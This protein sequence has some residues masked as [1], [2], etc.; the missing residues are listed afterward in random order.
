MDSTLMTRAGPNTCVEHDDDQFSSAITPSYS[1]TYPRPFFNLLQGDAR[2][3]IPSMPQVHC[4][5]TSPPY[6]RQRIYGDNSAEEIGQN[7]DVDDFLAD[8]VGVF[9]GIDLH[10]QGSVWVNLG[11]KRHK[12]GMLLCIPERFVLAMAHAGFRLI[13]R[14]IWAKSEAFEDGTT[15]GNFAPE[16]CRNRLNDKAQEPFYRFVKSDN[17]WADTVAVQIQRLNVE[18]VRYLPADL[19][20]VETAINGRNLHTIWNVRPGQ[21]HEK[22]HAVFPP[23]LCERPVAMTCPPFV[24]PD[25]SL[26]RRKVESVEYN[27][28][29]GRRQIGR[30][31][32]TLPVSK[33]GR[34]DSG[35]AYVPR[36]PISKGWEPIMEG[37]TS[38][39]VFDP[40]CGTGTVGAVALRLGRSF[41]GI[42]L[43]GE[44]VELARTRC[45][46]AKRFVE[47]NYGYASLY[48]MITIDQVE[49]RASL[50]Q[51]GHRNDTGSHERGLASLFEE[52]GDCPPHLR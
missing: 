15:N 33:T 1:R 21:T 50:L 14:V 51:G 16:P 45:A 25:G 31:D 26:P 44:Y 39:I 13:D 42:D 24:N 6:F 3:L 34:N 4:V 28:G 40:F 17:A 20:S 8:L 49:L 52:H 37:A 35:R 30:S 41:I 36:M 22:H 43:Y 23:A 46:D 19:M 9:G 2:K 5:V 12:N 38:G 10:P 11:D 47:T 29:K 48:D 32:T 27:E 18:S 7:R